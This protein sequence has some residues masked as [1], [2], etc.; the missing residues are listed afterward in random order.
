M[1]KK[2][3]RPVSALRNALRPD[4]IPD[5]LE[6]PTGLMGTIPYLSL[7]GNRELQL[8]GCCGILQYADD[9]IILALTGGLHSL[10]VTGEKLRMQTYSRHAVT[11]RGIIRSLEVEVCEE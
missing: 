3:F 6:L 10:T 8:C 2:S 7:Q 1:Q 5:R 4:P 11:V 9:R